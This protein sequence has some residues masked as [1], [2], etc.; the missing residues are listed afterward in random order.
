M[1]EETNDEEGVG[2]GPT[3]EADHIVAVK[4]DKHPNG[5]KKGKE[6]EHLFKVRWKGCGKKHDSWE[7]LTNLEGEEICE[8]SFSFLTSP[9]DAKAHVLQIC[10]LTYVLA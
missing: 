10:S 6:P 1:N 5:E 3:F 4:W 2:R 8:N 9:D 7:P